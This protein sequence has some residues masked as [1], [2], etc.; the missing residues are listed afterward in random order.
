MPAE[1]PGTVPFPVATVAAQAEVA[2]LATPAPIRTDQ[3]LHKQLRF[4]I[5]ISAARCVFTYVVVPVLSPL[6]QPA[7]ARDP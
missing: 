3:G 7:L 2:T 5:A 6:L 4:S 1:A